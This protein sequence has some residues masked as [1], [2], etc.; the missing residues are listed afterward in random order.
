MRAGEAEAVGP[1]TEEALAGAAD[2]V[3]PLKVAM[4]WGSSWADAKG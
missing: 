3:V 4:A 2:L 1:S